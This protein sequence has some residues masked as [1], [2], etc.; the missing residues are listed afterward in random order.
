MGRSRV[1]GLI[2][3][4]VNSEL[5]PVGGPNVQKPKKVNT[6]YEPPHYAVFSILLLRPLF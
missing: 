4:E 5:E 2:V 1:Q 3:S 6:N